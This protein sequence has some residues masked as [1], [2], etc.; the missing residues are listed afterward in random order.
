M[1]NKEDKKTEDNCKVQVKQGNNS[2]AI[3]GNTAP[4]D[5]N[6]RQTVYVNDGKVT[7]SDQNPPESDDVSP[8]KP[9]DQKE[10]PDPKQFTV[11]KVWTRE[12]GAYC[13][14]TKTEGQRDGM[15]EFGPTTKQM[16]LM[17]LL[18]YKYPKGVS[19][20][21][22]VDEVYSKEKKKLKDNPEQAKKLLRRICSL[23]G[24]I[25]K[26]KLAPAGINPDIVSTLG[27]DTTYQDSVILQVAHLYR[28]DDKKVGGLKIP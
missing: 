20:S 10:W 26:G 22:I 11:A 7:P 14:S 27:N 24:D 3:I 8:K 23:V 12:D 5:L 13:L 9:G 28:M 2:L 25:R 15:V 4:V 1:S 18:C 21:E 16:K 19:L 17:M 6:I